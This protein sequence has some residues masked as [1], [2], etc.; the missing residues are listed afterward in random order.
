MTS[1]GV[2]GGGFPWQT[3]G[4]WAKVGWGNKHLTSE[5]DYDSLGQDGVTAPHI[6]QQKKLEMSSRSFDESLRL[7]AYFYPPG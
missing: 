2:V 1:T 5:V 6:Q 3:S 7:K 4:I